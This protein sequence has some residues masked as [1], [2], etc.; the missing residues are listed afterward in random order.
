MNS[1]FAVTPTISSSLG[2][3]ISK[4]RYSLF[5]FG[6]CLAGLFLAAIACKFA[7]P[8]PPSPSVFDLGR[9]VYGFFPTAPEVNILS[10]LG[11]FH[12]ISQ[13][14]DVVLIQQP[15]PWNDFRAGIDGPSK[16]V[17]DIRNQVNMGWQNG[18]DAIFVVDPLNGLD[19]REFAGL[20][21]DL[22]GADFSNPVV[23]TA[24]QNYALR[25]ARDFHP[26]Y[27][28]LASEINTYAD[29][30]PE[31]FPNFLSL[32]R[33]T[34]KKIKAESPETKVFV[35]FQ[36]EDLNNY[37]AVGAARGASI[38]WDE[39][40]AFEP[41]LDLWVISS[42]PFVAFPSAADIPKNYYSPLLSRT[43]K[44]LAVAEGGFGSVDIPPAHG[45]PQDQVLYL[46]AIHDQ[47]GKR[48]AFWIYLV[49][50]DFNMDSYKQYLESQ[51]QGD[52]VETLRFF[53]VLGLRERDGTPKPALAGWDGFR[54]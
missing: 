34:H 17:D 18:V 22:A 1:A 32:Y 54:R 8:S 4:P 52:K 33:E 39:I 31:D 45:T 41:D 46:N 25:L 21:P 23:R 47:I 14:G 48:L 9:T 16:T 44:P 38:K 12:A 26:R 28:G 51:G 2:R 27:L 30:Y 11:T 43:D 40:E 20:P 3:A 53:S 15:V 7:Q 6:A 5:R 37:D 10:V 13:H 35:T 19:R 29:T 42:Y 50:D 24:Y 36:W 49:L